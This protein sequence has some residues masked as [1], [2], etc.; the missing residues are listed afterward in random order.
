MSNQCG[1]NE[2]W[3]PG[4]HLD[5]EYPVP[6]NEELSELW[7]EYTQAD[8]HPLEGV[9]GVFTPPEEARAVASVDLCEV[10]RETA[11]ALDQATGYEIERR[12]VYAANRWFHRE[13]SDHDMEQS[14]VVSI[15]RVLMHAGH[16]EPVDGIEGIREILITWREQG[17]YVVANTATLPG[18]E[19]GTIAHT[20]R[21]DLRDC[22]DALVLPRG[23]DGTSGVSKAGALAILGAEVG[24]PLHDKPLVHIDDARHHIE[25]FRN[26]FL[27]H[28]QAAF[29]M[30]YSVGTHDGADL[31]HP[32]TSL[33]SFEA[34]DEH[35]KKH[36]VVR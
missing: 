4:M 14:V 19:A 8:A 35:F 24:L 12:S 3:L 1:P 33:E 6:T 31:W 10:V 11:F 16:I 13:A 23:W 9:Y 17:V 29:F 20:L 22:F 26:D 2:L 5:D 21:R 28:T 36:G 34:A 27:E 25:G 32:M 15:V 18:C 7:S 30:P